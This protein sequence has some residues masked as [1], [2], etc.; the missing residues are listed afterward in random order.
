MPKGF[1][2]DC[3]C[4]TERPDQGEG[5]ADCHFF[6]PGA[7]HQFPRVRAEDWCIQFRPRAA[8]PAEKPTGKAEEPAP[9]PDKGEDRA[10]RVERVTR[11]A[12]PD[13]TR[14]APAAKPA[15]KPAAKPKKPA[16]KK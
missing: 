8:A 6:P 4:A 1:C 15:E 13:Q 10:G 2:K 12:E 7:G 11:P 9:A 5:I 16:A 14:A 3:D